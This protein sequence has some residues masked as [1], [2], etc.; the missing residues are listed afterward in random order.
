MDPQYLRPC[1]TA[2]FQFSATCLGNWSRN[3]GARQVTEE[4]QCN[5]DFSQF[6]LLRKALYEVELSSTFR[7]G[8]QQPITPLYSVSPLLILFSQIYG[9][10]NKGACTHALLVFRSEGLW[11]REPGQKYCK[12]LR[13]RWS[14]NTQ[15]RQLA[16]LHF[17]ALGDKLLRKLHSGTGPLVIRSINNEKIVW[18]ISSSM[19]SKYVLQS[20]S[21]LN[22]YKF[23]AHGFMLAGTLLYYLI[24]FCRINEVIRIF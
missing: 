18:N 9:S 24:H 17:Q 6:F 12:L 19:S 13:S 16:A 23:A 10:S 11:I 14:V 4:L 8:L 2:Q 7:N 5:M 22:T 3:A 15:P 21:K 20:T 1:Y